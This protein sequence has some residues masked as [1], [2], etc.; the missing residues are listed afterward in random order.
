MKDRACH[1]VWIPVL[2][3]YRFGITSNRHAIGP[4]IIGNTVGLLVNTGRDATLSVRT[5]TGSYPRK[6]D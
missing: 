3:F 1:S 4:S 2:I 6:R 5:T